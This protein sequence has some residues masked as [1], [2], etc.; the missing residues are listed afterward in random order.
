MEVAATAQEVAELT[1]ARLMPVRDVASA[2]DELRAER[3]DVVFN[4]CEGVAG[5]PAWEMHFALALEM[6]GIPFTGADPT[7]IGICSD[8]KL[9]KQL[10]ETA[11]IAVP[12]NYAGQSAGLWMVKPVHED[13]GIGIDAS[14][15]CAT[16]QQ[17]ADRIEHVRVTYDQP[18]LVEEFIDGTELSQAIY[19]GRDG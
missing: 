12:Q 7:A 10:L 15:V 1:G 9:T 11:G 13:A 16:P 14:S 18:A 6:L 4:L 2:L 8:K 17:V 3:P 5:R 19:F